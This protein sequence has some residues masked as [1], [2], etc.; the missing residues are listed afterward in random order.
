[1]KAD[2]NNTELNNKVATWDDLVE[3]NG[4]LLL[5][6]TDSFIDAIMTDYFLWGK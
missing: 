2:P 4:Q 1:M 3:P 6:S 5:I